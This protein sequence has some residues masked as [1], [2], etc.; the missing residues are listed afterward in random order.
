MPTIS[1]SFADALFKWTSILTIALGFF[2]AVS[3]S[4]AYWASSVREQYAER[5]ISDNELL[6]ARAN[7]DAAEARQKTA[8]I[9]SENLR[10]QAKLEEERIARLKLERQIAPRRLSS[11]NK[12][13]LVVILKKF[14][15]Q[16][17][18]LIAP[19]SDEAKEYAIDFVDVFKEAGW[20]I[21][22]SMN[23]THVTL[24][25]YD[26]EPQGLRVTTV[27]VSAEATDLHR[28]G[29]ALVAGLQG[30]QLSVVPIS[31]TVAIYPEDSEIIEFNVGIKPLE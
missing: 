20:R 2:S 13:E 26:R 8:V 4:V 25:Q 3:A 24:V 12:T 22:D 15:G 16:K 1:L 30:Q 27:S 28:A 18:R 31:S 5:R 6:T 21:L 19:Q 17:I 14:A 9:E 10:L 29:T 23:S 11:A 7:T